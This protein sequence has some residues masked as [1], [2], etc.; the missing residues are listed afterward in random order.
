[1]PQGASKGP[2]D[3]TATTQTVRQRLADLLRTEEL[4]AHELSQRAGIPE[5]DVAGHLRHLEHTLTQTSERL[6]TLAPFCIQCGFC[7]EQR[8][9]HTRPSRCPRCKS[10]RLAPPRFCIT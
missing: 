7:F 10:E 3:A 2:G 9:K 4:T 1:M 5:H 8:A 6:R